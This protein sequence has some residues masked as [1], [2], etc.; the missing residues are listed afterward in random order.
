MSENNENEL[1]DKLNKRM[2]VGLQDENHLEERMLS[3][4]P[5]LNINEHGAKGIA[6]SIMKFRDDDPKIR[7]DPTRRIFLDE[8]RSNLFFKAMNEILHSGSYFIDPDDPDANALGGAYYFNQLNKLYDFQGWS[9]LDGMFKMA[10][11]NSQVH[12]IIEEFTKRYPDISKYTAEEMDLFQLDMMSKLR[13]VFTVG[14]KELEDSLEILDKMMAERQSATAL[15]R[16]M[17]TGF[18]SIDEKLYGGFEPGRL[19]I[20]GARPAIGKTALLV[21]LADHIGNLK[22]NP[23]MDETA[24]D[25]TEGDIAR[26]RYRVGFYSL[27]MAK[28][29][30]L[31]RQT[32][33]ETSIPVNTLPHADDVQQ[34]VISTWM[35][36]SRENF[37]RI[38]IKDDVDVN[39]ED[40]ER[41]VNEARNEDRPYSAIMVD[42]LQLLN[43][44]IPNEVQ[45]ISEA[46]RG[47]KKIAKKY[48]V[49][50]IALA[51]LKRES[52]SALT[53]N[54]EE[55]TLSML[56]GSGSMEQDADVVMFLSRSDF[57]DDDASDL[58]VAKLKIAKNRSGKQGAVQ[59]KYYK[60]TQKMTELREDDPLN[61][62][63]SKMGGQQPAEVP[64]EDIPSLVEDEDIL[65]NSIPL[66]SSTRSN[67]ELNAI[68]KNIEKDGIKKKQK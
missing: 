17:S 27:E 8:H 54:T 24:E 65:A 23:Y 67:E 19:Y 7:K 45:R 11:K 14:S 63:K 31:D 5:Y 6:R 64:D 48:K 41:A 40:I 13:Q 53:D 38:Y 60:S 2:E 47:L 57:Y 3:I 39:I 21:N 1:M 26:N 25:V 4:L 59:I 34:A 68:L 15:P 16:I 9:E 58:S 35:L 12:N 32:G 22:I 28:E 49:A 43:P 46:S 66:A 55:I 62:K 30:I 51:Q 56:R 10:R 36:K 29:Q 61:D 18:E 37:S 42:Y 44:T 50:V 52:D 33:I 20:I